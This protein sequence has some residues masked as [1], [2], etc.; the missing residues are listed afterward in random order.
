[1]ARKL[2]WPSWWAVIWLTYIIKDLTEIRILSKIIPSLTKYVFKII[3]KL[4]K[5]VLLLCF[6]WSLTIVKAVKVAIAV[7]P[8]IRNIPITRPD[9]C[10]AH[11]KATTDVP[12]IVFHMA[13]LKNYCSRHLISRFSYYEVWILNEFFDLFSYSKLR[14][15]YSTFM[16][17][18]S[19]KKT[20]L[21]CAELSNLWIL[22]NIYSFSGSCLC[23]LLAVSVLYFEKKLGIAWVNIP[24]FINLTH[25]K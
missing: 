16:S 21:V 12:I 23:P 5:N 10:N 19:H 22:R 14:K 24:K 6:V 13:N 20:Y 2:K 3:Q 25:I 8:M 9:W 11:G 1:M 7:I 4:M 15:N 18:V 17:L